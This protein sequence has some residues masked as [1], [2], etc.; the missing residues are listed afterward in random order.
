[1][2]SVY[3]ARLLARAKRPVGA[4]EL[5]APDRRGRAENT[6]CGDEIELDIEL[7]ASAIVRVA[8]RARGCA[9]TIAS[10]SMLAE[11]LPGLAVSEALGRATAVRQWTL[12]EAEMPAGL[13]PLE[14]VRMF[15]AR[16]KCVRLP[17]DALERALARDG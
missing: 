9:F 15:P 5:A 11:T 4:G 16:A 12:G 2:M 17:W 10:A 13:E 8:H 14:L 1:M 3:D 7:S 6:I